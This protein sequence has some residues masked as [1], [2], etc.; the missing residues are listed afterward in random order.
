MN[1][2]V[3]PPENQF[4]AYGGPADFHTAGGGETAASD[5][6]QEKQ[7]NLRDSRPRLNGGGHHISGGGRIGN[8]LGQRI[9]EAVGQ[10][11]VRA[12]ERERQTV[13]NGNRQDQSQVDFQFVVSQRQP[14][15]SA[16]NLVVH[17]EIQGAHNCEDADDHLDVRG[18]NICAPGSQCVHHAGGADGGQCVDQS[19]ERR[20]AGRQKQHIFRH[21]QHQIDAERHHHGILQPCGQ[22]GRIS[23]KNVISH[24]PLV[25]DPHGRE[26]GHTEDDQQHASQPVVDSPPDEEAVVDTAHVPGGGPGGG[27]ARHSFE[28]CIGQRVVPGGQKI[29]DGAHQ[30]QEE[31]QSQ[32]QQVGVPDF[33]AFRIRVLQFPNGDESDQTQ[34]QKQQCRTQKCPDIFGFVII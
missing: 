31:K 34:R 16:V 9:A 18:E 10:T 29:R 7:R 1:P 8:C 2:L 13:D 23:G 30:H 24:D 12:L 28:Y 11:A 6:N 15:P 14:P 21:R 20:H 4:P 27:P 3:D 32:N 26:D 33:Q 25:L 17:H 22:F 19:I 5:Q